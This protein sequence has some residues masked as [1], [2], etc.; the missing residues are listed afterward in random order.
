VL[1]NVIGNPLDT[2]IALSHLIFEGTLDLFPGLK[3]CSAHGGGY[4]ASYMGRSDHGCLTFPHR[5]NRTLRKRPTEYLQQLYYD[6][7]IF[8]PEA[9]RHLAANVGSSQIMLGTDYPYTRHQ[10]SIAQAFSIC[11]HRARKSGR[12]SDYRNC[13][14][15][16]ASWLLAWARKK[17][18]DVA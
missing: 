12:D 14:Y 5:C 4:L 16:A 2:T 8:T 3:I 15:C 11:R 1:D 13:A 18:C 7:L 6:A 9:L 17:S 10:T